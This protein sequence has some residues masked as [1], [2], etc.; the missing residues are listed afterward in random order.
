MK[1]SDV[2]VIILES[3]EDYQATAGAEEAHGIKYLGLVKVETDAGIVGYADL[4]TQPHVARTI[5][6]APSEG[7]V[8][9]FKGLRSLLIGE[10]PFDVERLWHKMYMGSVYYGRRGAAMQVISGIVIALD[11]KSTRL[12][13]SHL[14]ISY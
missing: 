2:D 1:I 5:V 8:L 12:N 13:S 14:G 9:G 10:D 3:P 7:S 6:N 11:R 4:E